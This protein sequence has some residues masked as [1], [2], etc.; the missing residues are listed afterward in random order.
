MTGNDK[1]IYAREVLEMVTVGVEL[2]RYLEET[3]AMERE[4]FLDTISK[5]LPLV[6]LKGTLLPR[7]ELMDDAPEDCVTEENYDIVRNN[8]A[9]IMGD[10]DDYLDVFVEDMKYSDTPILCTISENLADIYQ[11]L[12][13]FVSAYKLGSEEQMMSALA[14]AKENFELYWG[15]KTVNVMRAIHE[16]KYG[17]NDI[18]EI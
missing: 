6:Y 10:R 1:P 3:E 15:Q 7:Y 9:C 16:V 11:D 12:K 4:E 2:C 18:R 17:E 13:N 5:L 14:V 8:I